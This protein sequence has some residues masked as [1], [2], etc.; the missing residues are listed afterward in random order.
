[1]SFDS[2]KLYS[3]LPAVYRIRDIEL[4]EQLDNLLTPSEQA[5]LQL[6]RSSSPLTEKQE[7][8]LEVLEEKR[9]RGPL[10]ALLSV[11]AE[12]SVVLADNLEQ[13]YDDFFI[14]TCAE[15]A[16]PYIGDL[17]GVRGISVFPGARFTERAFVANTMAYRRRKGTA[18]VLEQL[19]RD[20]T[21]WDASVVEYFKLLATTQYM[22]HIRRENLSLSDIGNS[23][24]LEFLNTPFDKLARTVDVRRIEPRRGKYNIP[25]IGIYLWR[26]GSYSVTNAPAFKLDSGR[27]LFDALGKD[28]RVYNDPETEDEITHLALP[29]N[30]PMPL[31]RRILD[32][33]LDTYYGPNKSLLVTVDGVDIPIAESS[34]PGAALSVCICDLS[35]WTHRPA[36]K[37]AIDPVLGRIAFPVTS[38]PLPAPTS[39]QVTYH[40]GFSAPMGAGE[41]DREESFPSP[42]VDIK[43]PAGQPTIQQAINQMSPAGGVIA[44]TNSSVFFETPAIHLDLP[45]K[46]EIELRAANEQR[47]VLALS[48]EFVVSGGD[49]T[50]VT[51]N[52][53][54]IAGVL[55]VPA[56]DANGNDNKLRTLRLRHC[57]LVP[58]DISALQ[59]MGGSPPVTIPARAA[60]PVLIV[61]SKDTTIEIEQC[62]VGAIQAN[63][64][65]R[66]SIRNSIIDASQTDAVSYAG[67]SGDDPGAPLTIENSTVIGKVYTRTMKLA[68]NTIFFSDLNPGDNWPAPVRAERLQQGC[69]RFCYVPPG[70]QL[71]RLFR[72][73]PEADG[74]VA[75]VRPVFTSQ[76]YGDAAYCQLSTACAVEITTGADDQA[77]MGAF[78]DLYE[79]LREANLRAALKEYLRFG[80]EA[81]IFYAS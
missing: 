15:W 79:P 3:L 5:E 68:S 33:H 73:Q 19:A 25:N 37:V 7:R 52:G 61:E 69:V 46:R 51:L 28:I 14:E 4:A 63:S 27:Y 48:G 76:R 53:F 16:V 70:S 26:L 45:K 34:P 38:P 6:L 54:V 13:L 41:Y 59:G 29:I 20:V 60:A 18:A 55:R 30:V 17:L 35:G 56:K 42:T 72:C 58:G 77:E 10:K 44:V 49:E 62:I 47:P 40:Y 43:V 66:V 57:T 81:G 39:V 71:P 22:N 75:R 80:L 74:D 9:Q 65:A 24:W 11:I 32:R 2:E 64:G 50:D 21:G 67:L 78:H 12:Q 36:G 31:E 1:M 8:R 23:H